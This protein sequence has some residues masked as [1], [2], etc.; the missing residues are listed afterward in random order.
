MKNWK[1]GFITWVQSFIAINLLS[2]AKQHGIT[3]KAKLIG[4]CLN[5]HEHELSNRRNETK[6]GQ[7][8]GE[9]PT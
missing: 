9:F 8:P 5:C 6:F 4:F 7:D 3:C 1:Q 2:G